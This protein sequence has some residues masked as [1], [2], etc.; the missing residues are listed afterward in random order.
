MWHPPVAA[1][2]PTLP[3]K[4]DVRTLA[5]HLREVQMTPD[6]VEAVVEHIDRLQR[7]GHANGPDAY[8]IQSVRGD[9]IAKKG[10]GE[11]LREA[12]VEASKRLAARGLPP[13]P[14]TTA[15]TLRRTYISIALLANNFDVKWS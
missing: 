1:P 5:L 8:L 14:H 2:A 12:A 9:R 11:A 4:P 15:H 7:A 6:L 3:G 13:L 10:V